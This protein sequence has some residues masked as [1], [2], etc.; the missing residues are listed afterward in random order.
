MIKETFFC[1]NCRKKIDSISQI[2][3]VED[4]S[5]RGFCSEECIK[6]FYSPYMRVLE[7]EEQKFRNDLLMDDEDDLLSYLADSELLQD[8]LNYPDE[9]WVLTNA[10][11]QRF[12]THIK[13]IEVDGQALSLI[14]VCSYIEDTPSFVYYRTL[15]QHKALV[16]KYRR[17]DAVV[18][19]LSYQD[20]DEQTEIKTLNPEEI[21]EIDLKKS[22]LLADL[23]NLR[24]SDDIPFEEFMDFESF[25]EKTVDNPDEVYKYE[26]EAGDEI[27]SYIR[28][29]KM[30]SETFFYIALALS[31]RDG[32]KSYILPILGFP[33]VDP[34]LYPHYAKGEIVKRKLSN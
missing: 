24:S 19:D 7:A 10:V 25:L 16:Q 28:S 9:V 30:D 27:Y 8:A 20:D 29:F 2:Y 6:E 3:Y 31:K 15:T 26:D 18:T 17:E 23:L 33:S 14:L 13:H 11:D 32:K 21:D 22:S 34:E 5:D 4:H 1:E 12:F